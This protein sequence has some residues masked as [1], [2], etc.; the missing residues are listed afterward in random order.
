MV[1]NLAPR[2]IAWFRDFRGVL[3]QSFQGRSQMASANSILEA[4]VD[5]Y[6]EQPLKQRGGPSPALSIIRI[7][8]IHNLKTR[9]DIDQINIIMIKNCYL[10]SIIECVVDATI[11]QSCI[12]A[13][14]KFDLT[15]QSC[16]V[17]EHSNKPT[18]YHE[19]M[20][21]PPWPASAN[22][23]AENSP[24]WRRLENDTFDAP[25]DQSS[26]MAIAGATAI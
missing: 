22:T 24:T 11:S 26:S 5:E 19:F 23:L 7:I 15:E 17:I 4:K 20:H 16:H 2:S 9:I 1:I 12:D 25:S 10:Y 14:R 8:A 21:M 13:L 6:L 3:R 18:N